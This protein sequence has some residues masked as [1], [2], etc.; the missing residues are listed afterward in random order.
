[1][2]KQSERTEADKQTEY[3]WRSHSIVFFLLFLIY[4][5]LCFFFIWN[6][7]TLVLP[8]GDVYQTCKKKNSVMICV[9]N[10]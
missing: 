5:G 3:T 7:D 8:E 1:M 6:V 4:F 10:M 9:Y 2:G